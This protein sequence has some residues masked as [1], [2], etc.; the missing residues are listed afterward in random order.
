MTATVLQFR[1]VRRQRISDPARRR[2]NAVADLILM[3][4]QQSPEAAAILTRQFADILGRSLELTR[5]HPLG[6]AL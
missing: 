1:H 4:H 6:C 5:R 3:L 2:A